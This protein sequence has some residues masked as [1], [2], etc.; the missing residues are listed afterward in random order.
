MPTAN[1]TGGAQTPKQH[2]Y[3][4]PSKGYNRECDQLRLRNTMPKL[5]P[6]SQALNASL[7]LCKYKK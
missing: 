3:N 7:A 6:A 2:E 5:L 4:A 1:A